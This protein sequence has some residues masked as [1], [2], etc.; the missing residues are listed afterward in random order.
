MNA[1]QLSQLNLYRFEVPMEKEFHHAS[2]SHKVS[3]GVLL[4]ATCGDVDGWGE[5][6]PRKYVTGETIDSVIEEIKS[7]NMHKLSNTLNIGD[8]SGSINLLRHIEQFFEKNEIGQCTRCLIEL[9]L[10]DVLLKFHKKSFLD[11]YKYLNDNVSLNTLNQLN[12]TQVVDLQGTDELLSQLDKDKRYHPKRIKIKVDADL[13]RTESIIRSIR[14]RNIDCDITLDANE[15]WNYEILMEAGERLS[16]YRLGRIEEPLPARSWSELSGFRQ[17]YNINLM[18]DE[19]FSGVED[20]VLGE[21]YRAF[22]TLN[23]RMSKCGGFFESLRFIDIA[24]RKGKSIYFGVHVGEIGPLWACQRALA[25]CV[26][27]SV[28]V[29]VGKQDQWFTTPTTVPEYEVDRTHHSANVVKGFGHG[30]IPSDYLYHHM[31]CV[32][33]LKNL[34]LR[35]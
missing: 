7:L 13:D 32:Y 8:F 4:K 17:K 24:K 21:R 12:Y 18:L 34:G 10:L 6:A 16:Q 23:I 9:T 22:D 27:F 29:E 19:S 14:S 20:I 35:S 28:G 11:L 31:T 33:E 5:A 30:V 2:F 1:I 25:S 26:K 15:G 3:Q